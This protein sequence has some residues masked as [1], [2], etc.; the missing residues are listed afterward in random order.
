MQFNGIHSFRIRENEKNQSI[1][2]WSVMVFV[3]ADIVSV[4]PSGTRLM[5]DND[6]SL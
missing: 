3:P 2:S 4:S 1:L 5:A 6:L